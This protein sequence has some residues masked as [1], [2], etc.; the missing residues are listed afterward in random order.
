MDRNVNVK[1]QA[2]T[3]SETEYMEAGHVGCGGCGAI[4]G[5]RFALKAMGPKT[6]A[7]ISASCW[8]AICGALKIP[9]THCAFATAGAWASGIRAGLD[10]LGDKETTVLAWA[11]DGGTFDIG[12]QSLSAAA[13]RN[14]NFIYICNDNEAYMNT[15]IQ[16]SSATPPGAW[17]TTT[18]AHGG[19][20]QPKKDID[21]IMA[22]P[23]TST[24]AL[25]VDEEVKSSGRL[26][27][28]EEIMAWIRDGQ[29]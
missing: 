23:I 28:K 18:P 2:V 24:P 14:T 16:R 4:H 3:L 10:V 25:V 1:H 29:R 8:S 5:M 20:N 17:T 11:G 22:Y 27:R 26:P 9:F 13:E 12:L 15:G 6:V 21:A 7:V 19:K